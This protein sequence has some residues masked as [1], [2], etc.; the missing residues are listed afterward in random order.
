MPRLGQAAR[1][2]E[3]Q[4]LSA[5]PAGAGSS[6]GEG[7]PDEE[8]A[9]ALTRRVGTSEAQR[10]LLRQALTHGSYVNEHTDESVESNERLEFLGD[11]VVSLVVSQA[12]YERHPDEDEGALTARR[13][14]I[15]ST[16]GLARLAARV[17][18]DAVIIL[19]QGAERSGERRRASVLAASFEAVAGAIY[20]GRGLD[21][22]RE[23]I[24]DLIADELDAA[25]PV[26]TLKSPKSRLQESAYIRWG[27]PPS[28]R[29]VSAL[30]P[31]HAKHYIVE[32][33]A[34]G[35]VLGRGEGANRRD[36]ETAAAAEALE[37]LERRSRSIATHAT[38]DEATVLG[39]DAGHVA[40]ADDSGAVDGEDDRG[41]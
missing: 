17:G 26:A 39:V 31:D 18:L 3:A 33:S 21:A 35:H 32:V 23:W 15:V 5:P 29:V 1:T 37:A 8:G 27:G 4:A 16:Q 13:A 41:A 10:D 34:L 19:G 24:L 22:A 14:A 30:G 38:V 36:A 12:L 28:Y 6:G 25:A 11:S 7:T 40:E 9:A 2:P 20:L